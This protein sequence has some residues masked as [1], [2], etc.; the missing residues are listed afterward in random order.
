M[1]APE[2]GVTMETYLRQHADQIACTA[3]G[4]CCPTSC[5][6]K[7]GTSCDVHPKKI[8][9]EARMPLC[10]R[11]PVEFF[12]D[13]GIACEPVLDVIKT[14][15]DITPDVMEQRYPFPHPHRDL[16]GCTYV[17]PIDHAKIRETVIHTPLPVHRTFIPLQ[18]V[19]IFESG[20]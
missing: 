6:F 9:R 1:N 2:M 15:T 18:S 8:G 16:P 13:H 19:Q 7:N 20:R 4:R 11:S 10:L 3:C 5:A 12:L 14:L 17:D